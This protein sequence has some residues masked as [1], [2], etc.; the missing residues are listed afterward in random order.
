MI[1]KIAAVRHLH[2]RGLIMGFFEKPVY[3]FLVVINTDCR[4]KLLS[5]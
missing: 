2:F 5:F 1:F 4:S 3:D